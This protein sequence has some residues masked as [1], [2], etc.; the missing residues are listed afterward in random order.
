MLGFKVMTKANTINN[1]MT[2]NEQQN[3]MMCSKVEHDM[4]QIIT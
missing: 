3:N 4:Y 1:K 2:H